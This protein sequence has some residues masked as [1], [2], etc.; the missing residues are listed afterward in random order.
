M[1]SHISFAARSKERPW[2]LKHW[3]RVFE[4]HLSHGCLCVFVFCLCFN[5]FRQRS[6]IG[7]ILR[8][9]SPVE[10]VWERETGKSVRPSK[11]AIE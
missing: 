3:G 9:G 1:R 2:L 5:V 7:L 4:S 6:C 10:C 8:P 11:R